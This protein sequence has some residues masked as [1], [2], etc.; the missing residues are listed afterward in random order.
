MF[1][2]LYLLMLRC[3]YVMQTSAC[4]RVPLVIPML[5]ADNARVAAAFALSSRCERYEAM[6]TVRDSV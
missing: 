4:P 2:W 1:A 5:A 3:K 6:Q